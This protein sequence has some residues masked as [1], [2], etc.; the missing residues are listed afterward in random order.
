VSDTG[1]ALLVCIFFTIAAWR[2]PSYSLTDTV[3]TWII[4]M[5]TLGLFW[6]WVAEHRRA[7]R[8]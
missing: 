6:I 7:P 8:D 1:L 2:G 3:C 5:A 4:T